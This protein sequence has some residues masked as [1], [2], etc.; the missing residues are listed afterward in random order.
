MAFPTFHEIE[1]IAPKDPELYGILR[2]VVEQLRKQQQYTL[3]GE[4]S[5]E[6]VVAAR[7]G[8]HFI[9]RD[10]T[11][12]HAQAEWIKTGGGAEAA[13]WV[14]VHSISTLTGGTGYLLASASLPMADGEIPVGVV[15]GFNTVFT[16]AKVPSPASSLKFFVAGLLISA[17]TLAGVKVTLSVAPGLGAAVRA[18]YRF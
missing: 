7:V 1:G 17:Y 8:T 11:K 12:G 3:T 6:G 16:L 9:Q 10:L 15:D 18:W 13:G 4:G 14:K 2:K 5:P